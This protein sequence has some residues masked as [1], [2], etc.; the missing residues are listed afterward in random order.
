MF[1]AE[2]HRENSTIGGRTVFSILSLLNGLVD[3][4]GLS[5]VEKTE[6]ILMI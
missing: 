6:P 3:K 2:K 4:L 5:L 1:L